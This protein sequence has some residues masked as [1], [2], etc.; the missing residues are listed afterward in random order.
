MTARHDPARTVRA[1]HSEQAATH[2]RG[3]MTD[4]HD[5]AIQIFVVIETLVRQVVDLGHDAGLDDVLIELATLKRAHN[6]LLNLGLHRVRQGR[7][8][9]P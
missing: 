4:Y 5:A 7:L 8:L 1:V 3:V 9:H 6:A 2:D